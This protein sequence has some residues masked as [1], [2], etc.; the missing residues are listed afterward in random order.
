MPDYVA[1]LENNEESA[2]HVFWSKTSQS[3]EVPA[4]WYLLVHA[5]LSMT[6]SEN[7]PEPV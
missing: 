4:G 7:L 5:D 6:L 1:Y 3:F 2:I